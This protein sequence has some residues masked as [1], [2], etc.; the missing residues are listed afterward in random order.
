MLCKFTT[1]FKLSQVY[2]HQVNH[3]NIRVRNGC[4]R[5]L[6]DIISMKLKNKEESM[7]LPQNTLNHTKGRG[8]LL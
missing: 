3:V 7:T 1:Y 2:N 8:S 6:S 5:R 4:H